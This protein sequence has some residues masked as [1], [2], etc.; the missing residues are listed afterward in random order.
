MSTVSRIDPVL[1]VNTFEFGSVQRSVASRS[2]DTEPCLLRQD[3]ETHH[4]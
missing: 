2:L 3:G 4:L 1:L